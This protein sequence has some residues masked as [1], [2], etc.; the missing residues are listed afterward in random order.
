[1]ISHDK[2]RPAAHLFEDHH[3]ISPHDAQRGEDATAEE[4]DRGDQIGKPGAD[5]PMPSQKTNCNG[6]VL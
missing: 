3:Q 1:M 6:T 5:I 2:R 4:K